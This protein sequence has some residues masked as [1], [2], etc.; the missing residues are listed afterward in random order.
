MRENVVKL[1]NKTRRDIFYN[2]KYQDIYLNQ[3]YKVHEYVTVHLLFAHIAQLFEK[4]E[5]PQFHFF[6]SLFAFV[7]FSKR[8]ENIFKLSF[9]LSRV[10]SFSFFYPSVL[11]QLFPISSHV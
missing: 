9:S 7:Y 2:W 1:R 8:N 5:F 6:N 10:M 4:N 3:L 11:R